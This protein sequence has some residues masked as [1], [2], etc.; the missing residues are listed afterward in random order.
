MHMSETLL[1]HELDWSLIILPDQFF[2]ARKRNPVTV[3]NNEKHCHK[4]CD[5]SYFVSK[6]GNKIKICVRQL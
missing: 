3:S 5:Y 1:T 4:T 2:S 6:Y